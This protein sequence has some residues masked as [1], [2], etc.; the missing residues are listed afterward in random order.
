[1]IEMYGVIAMMNDVKIHS[2]GI[3]I[4]ASLRSLNL[5]WCNLDDNVGGLVARILLDSN[6]P[7]TELRIAHNPKLSTES[8][9]YFANALKS[10]RKLK[11]FNVYFLSF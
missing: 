8:A 11:I 3:P 9:K 10:N 6:S 1:M 5:S 4:K 2:K 7:L